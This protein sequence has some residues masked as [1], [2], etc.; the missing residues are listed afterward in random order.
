M[1]LQLTLVSSSVVTSAYMTSHQT[2]K[3]Y[4]QITNN[5]TTRP[6]A[7]VVRQV[8]QQ[9]CMHV[10][11][12]CLLH[13]PYAPARGI[14]P[15]DLVSGTC[16]SKQMDRAGRRKRRIV[17]VDGHAQARSRL[18][19]RWFL[20]C[21]ARAHYCGERGAMRM[22]RGHAVCDKR[23]PPDALLQLPSTC[24]GRPSAH[25]A[26]AH[27]SSHGGQHGHA[28]EYLRDFAQ[29]SLTS[30][31]R[32]E[33]SSATTMRA[34][35]FQSLRCIRDEDGARRRF[36][37]RLSTYVAHQGTLAPQTAVRGA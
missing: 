9:V 8:Q 25:A 15:S 23:G 7:R 24:F 2:H 4:I 37:V 11:S 22:S 33:K 6:L 5:K 26:S 29:S 12:R 21:Q 31:R 20:T 32:S 18:A 28:C 14:Q 27:N 35:L 13:C 1:L 19:T 10:C 16:N 36:S 30:M 34:H 3:L 17:E